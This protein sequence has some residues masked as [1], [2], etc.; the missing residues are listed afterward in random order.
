MPIPLVLFEDNHDLRNT[1]V[2]LLEAGGTYQVMGD[3]EN[4]AR[5]K[6]VIQELQPQVVVLD[7]NLP[8]MS[9]IDAIPIIKE[10]NP[11]VFVVMYTQFEED[12]KLFQ[13]LCAGADGYI[14][15]KTSPLKLVDAI[16]EVCNG[17]TPLS[18]AIAKKILHSFRQPARGQSKHFRLTPKETAILQL[19]IKGYSVKLIASE[20]NITY[21]TCRSHLRNIYRKL[22]V[23]CGKEAIAKIL[24]EKIIL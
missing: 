12:E 3:F 5:V 9:G 1:L 15:K 10:M 18:P 6:E 16:D 11:E 19:L 17:G 8:G 14:L 22:H 21:D 23:N 13:S 4:A 24:A 20:E 7:I 2:R